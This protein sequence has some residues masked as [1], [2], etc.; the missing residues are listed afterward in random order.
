MNRGL[1]TSP[2]ELDQIDQAPD[3]PINKSVDP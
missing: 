2:A 3:A 1:L